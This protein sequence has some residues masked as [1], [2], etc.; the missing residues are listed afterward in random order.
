MPGSSSERG[1]GREGRRKTIKGVL[2]GWL[3]PR[4]PGAQPCW[5]PL[6][7]ASEVSCQGTASQGIY[8]LTLS[9][10]G[11]GLPLRAELLPTPQR[12]PSRG[13]TD[14]PGPLRWELSAV[15]GTVLSSCRRAQTWVRAAVVSASVGNL[16]WHNRLLWGYPWLLWWF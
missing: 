8:L 5:G 14:R 3:P 12:K 2:M 11:W 10:I 15:V 1:R 6:D 16:K 9:L 7:Y 4:P 13:E